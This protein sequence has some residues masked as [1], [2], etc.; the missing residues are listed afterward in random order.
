[1]T[2]R[3]VAPSLV[4]LA[5]G[6]VLD[7]DR[8]ADV[9]RHLRECRRCAAR[10][11]EERAMSA[12]L[13]RLAQVLGEPAPDPQSE[14]ALLAA[15]DAAWTE[16]RAVAHARAWQPLA[17]AAV[18]ALGATAAWMTANR[19]AGVHGPDTASPRIAAAA[20]RV[21][22]PAAQP[23]ASLPSDTHAAPAAV[24]TAA[25]RRVSAHHGPAASR[26]ASAFVPWP[27]AET[28]PT[29]ESGHL[30]R[31]DLPTSMAISLGL[32]PPAAQ[33]GVVRAD[34]LVGQDGFARAVRVAP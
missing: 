15:F 29:F 7:A 20:P 21:E 22:S 12:A 2:C 28:L 11:A 34:I 23:A 17:A 3:T 33:A 30:M 5:R 13:G 4:D 6:I 27:G 8:Q 24:K 31:L 10:L 14:R 16:P 1:M 25:A 32:T 19:L 9:D 26:D 18:V